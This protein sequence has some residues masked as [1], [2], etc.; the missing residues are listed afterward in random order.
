MKGNQELGTDNKQGNSGDEGFECV[1]EVSHQEVKR[2]TTQRPPERTSRIPIPCN[3][4]YV[5]PNN[6]KDARKAAS[7]D[8]RSNGNDI[9]TSTKPASSLPRPVSS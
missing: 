4:A 1:G 9:T 5:T 7:V 6:F 3:S 2:S 8:S